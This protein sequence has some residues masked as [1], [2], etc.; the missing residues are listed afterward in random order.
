MNE[1]S[2]RPSTSSSVCTSLVR[3]SHART[4]RAICV[5]AEARVR[6]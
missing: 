6:E 3:R 1:P 4:E 2:A 5:Y